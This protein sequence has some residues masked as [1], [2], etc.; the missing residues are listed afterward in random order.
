MVAAIAVLVGSNIHARLTRGLQR[1]LGTL[2]GVVLAAT[3]MWIDPPILVVLILA[4]FCQ[5]FIEMIILRNYAAGMIFIT[6]IALVMVNMA[7]PF[8][9]ETFIRNRVFET[10]IGVI[11]GMSVTI[12]VQLKDYD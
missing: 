12:A 11:V 2:V 8:P 5:G 6:V 9:Q 7:S 3:V 4:I 10:L 1:F